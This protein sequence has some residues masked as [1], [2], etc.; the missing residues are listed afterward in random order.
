[1]AE[2]LKSWIVV[3]V[4]AESGAARTDGSPVHS[5]AKPGRSTGGPSKEREVPAE[6]QAIWKS[7]ATPQGMMRAFEKLF[8]GLEDFDGANAAGE[9]STILAEHG[10]EEPMQFRD[11][12]AARACAR[13]LFFR[14]AE[15]AEH[16]HSQGGATHIEQKGTTEPT[17]G[18][19]DEH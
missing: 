1:M 7:M 19:T 8:Q 16:A 17:G 2:A 13:D 3:P 18:V 15:L 6:L 10:V 9:F 4:I 11:L 12:K 14:I 5:Q